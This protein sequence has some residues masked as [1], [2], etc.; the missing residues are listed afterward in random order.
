MS[1]F[2]DFCWTNF[3]DLE[4]EPGDLQIWKCRS[5]KSGNLKS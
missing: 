5:K 2:P 4:N 1:R 3:P